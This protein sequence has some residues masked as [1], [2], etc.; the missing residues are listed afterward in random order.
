MSDEP[1][2]LFSTLGRAL[3]GALPPAFLLLCVINVAFLAAVLWFLDN[4]SEARL[5]LIERIIDRC[6]DLPKS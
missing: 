3:I 2:G 1:T 4:Q 6:V 5:H